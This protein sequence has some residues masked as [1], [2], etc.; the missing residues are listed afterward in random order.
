MSIV[1]KAIN[2]AKELGADFSDVREEIYEYQNVL[3]MNGGI[4]TIGRTSL[5]G[6]SIRVLINSSWGYAST[7]ASSW[8]SVKE[9]VKQAFKLAKVAS[10][11]SKIKEKLTLNVKPITAKVKASVKKDPLDV[12]LDEK[13]SILF[14]LDSAQ[15]NFD[16]RIVNS[17][18]R[19]LESKKLIRLMNTEGSN[20]EWEEIKTNIACFSFAKENGKLQYSYESEYGSAGFELVSNLNIEE[21][22]SKPAKEAV[23]LLSAKKPPSGSLI[24]IVD[25][26]ISGLLAHEV[27]GHASEADEVVKKR[28]FL[29]EV[30]GKK[31]AS[32]LIT[33]VDDGSIVGAYGSIPFD[34]EGTKSG[35]TV[36]I[37]KGIYKG[38][39]HS[40]E[41]ASLMGVNPTG[42]GRAQDIN[43]R[44]WVRMTNTFFEAGDWNLEEIISETKSGLLAIKAIS[45]MEDP[46]G[47]G[48]EGRAL[49]GFVIENGEKTD[50]VRSFTLTGK[51]LEILKTVDAVSKNFK[52]SGGHCG[53]GEEDW[54]PVTT[55]GAYIRANIIIGGG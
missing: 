43:R 8:E 13:L 37:D 31:V 20:L 14:D 54:V 50:L 22:G 52:L 7:T 47:G 41:T 11:R 26:S 21:F 24:V 2:F 36:I 46:V 4:R 32:E 38:Y 34:S 33:M 39:M 28:S 15:R 16:K 27:M 1:E 12:S 19:Y 45:G 17:N 53:K 30:V 44:V 9:T 10:E 35:R 23:N 55:G 48:F 29:S 51:A 42:N 40:L 18:T 49:M 25:P 5:S 3:I 6:V